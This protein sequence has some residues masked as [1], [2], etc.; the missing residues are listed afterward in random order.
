MKFCCFNYDDLKP[1]T[2]FLNSFKY[3]EC[4]T[5]IEKVVSNGKEFF[6]FKFAVAVR[7]ED[8]DNIKFLFE[9][10]KQKNSRNIVMV[11][12]TDCSFLL[13]WAVGR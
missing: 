13:E 9:E 3:R 8:I 1:V 10:F 5:K 6:I 7:F 11:L 12:F 2:D 4:G